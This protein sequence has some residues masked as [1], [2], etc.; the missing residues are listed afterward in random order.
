MSYDDNN[1][2]HRKAVD[3]WLTRPRKNL[4]RVVY[5]PSID[6]KKTHHNLDIDNLGKPKKKPVDI[7]KRILDASAL[8]DG[9]VP[10]GAK[11]PKALMPDPKRLMSDKTEQYLRK[12]LIEKMNRKP[13]D[14]DWET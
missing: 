13:L 6:E 4:D 11:V 8:Y 1:P 5:D 9:Y 14:R 3:E 12:H 7:Q 10:E 2:E